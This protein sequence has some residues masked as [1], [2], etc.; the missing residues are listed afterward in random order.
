M[1]KGSP[2]AGLGH[3]SGLNRID[4]F[5]AGNILQWFV[6]AATPLLGNLSVLYLDH[7]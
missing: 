4:P 5:P 1:F 7:K 6:G 2:A 3:F